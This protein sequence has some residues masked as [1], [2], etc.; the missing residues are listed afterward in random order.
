MQ[1]SKLSQIA[2]I[3]TDVNT[4]NN[5]KLFVNPVAPESNT[6]NQ[7]FANHNST[8]SYYTQTL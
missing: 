7:N 5:S 8:F 3:N 1:V 6:D 2:K 4:N